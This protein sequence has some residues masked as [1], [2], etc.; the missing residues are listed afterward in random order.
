L[1][2]YVWAS[3]FNLEPIDHFKKL[4]YNA[5][6]PITQKY[7]LF[8]KEADIWSEVNAISELAKTSKTRTMGQMLFDLIPLFASP[9]F[10][11]EHWIIEIMNEYHWVKNWNVSPGNLDNISAFRLDCWTIIENELNQIRKVESNNG[12]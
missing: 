4:P 2:F 12:K 5:Q 1:S 8:R 6:S 7:I 3:Y 9:N 11:E 10:F